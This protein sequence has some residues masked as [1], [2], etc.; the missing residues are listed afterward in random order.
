MLLQPYQWRRGLHVTAGVFG[1]GSSELEAAAKRVTQLSKDP[2][3]EAKLKI[4]AL[5][6]QVLT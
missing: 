1:T 6:K 3:N 5:Y 4:Y 2:G